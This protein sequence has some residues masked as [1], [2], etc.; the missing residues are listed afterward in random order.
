MVKWYAE[1]CCTPSPRAQSRELRS[2]SPPNP[3][4]P[5]I[6][7]TVMFSESGSLCVSDGFAGLGGIVAPVHQ[8]QTVVIEGLDAD[9][10]P[11]DPDAPERVEIGRRQVVGVGFEGRPS[12]W[13]QSKLRAACSRS[14]EEPPGAE[15]RG[16]ASEI[17]GPDGLSAEIRPLSV[18]FAVHGFGEGFHPGGSGLSEEVAVGADA[19]QKGIWI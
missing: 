19:L 8:P 16:S 14:L 18:E 13:V 11:I 10:K 6:R 12:T 7:S 9:R 1:M 3:G 15:R 4:T 17:A 2:E 5:K